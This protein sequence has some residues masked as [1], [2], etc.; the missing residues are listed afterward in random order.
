MARRKAFR[1]YGDIPNLLAVPPAVRRAALPEI[2]AEGERIAKE[3]APKGRGAGSPKS[4][5]SRI[6][7]TVEREAAI[8]H[9]RSRAPHSHLIEFGVSGHSLVPGSGKRRWS[10]KRNPHKVIKVNGDPSI[11]RRGAFHGG[12]G[13]NPF[14][15]RTQEQLPA[16]ADKALQHVGERELEK[17]IQRGVEL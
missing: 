17:C 6:K 7:G 1:I 15:E 9:I 8:G 13:A 5:V 14:M 10:K 2:V 4:I 12:S 11:I 3:E 16:V